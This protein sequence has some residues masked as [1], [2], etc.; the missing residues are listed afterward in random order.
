[1]IVMDTAKCLLC[2][3][4]LTFP[5]YL[6]NSP[7]DSYSHQGDKLTLHLPPT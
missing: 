7:T 3:K 4:S 2:S 5:A 1:M 6:P